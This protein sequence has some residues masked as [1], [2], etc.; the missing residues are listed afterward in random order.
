MQR[1]A[2]AAAMATTSEDLLLA[3]E[4][5]EKVD[6]M[7]V[8]DVIPMRVSIW[9]DEEEEGLKAQVP[10]WDVDAVTHQC[11]YNFLSGW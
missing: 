1:S 8:E 4:N 6:S 7:S 11:L 10:A 9:G 5:V 2:A 3:E